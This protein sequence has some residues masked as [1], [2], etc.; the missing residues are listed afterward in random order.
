[1]PIYLAMPH[2]FL[3]AFSALLQTKF[4]YKQQIVYRENITQTGSSTL[5]LPDTLP[6]K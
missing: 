1:M 5:Y 2:K 3:T 6:A 4:I